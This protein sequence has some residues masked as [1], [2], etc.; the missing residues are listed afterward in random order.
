MGAHRG[1]DTHHNPDC[2]PEMHGE[3]DIDVEEYDQA[4]SQPKALFIGCQ[5]SRLADIDGSGASTDQG[6]TD[7]RRPRD[8]K[9]EGALQPYGVNGGSN[10]E[11][12]GE[13]AAQS[14][15]KCRLLEHQPPDDI[16]DQQSIVAIL[17]V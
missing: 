14:D 7:E 10:A 1:K 17:R 3:S 9:S 13:R 8:A 6:E 5:A 2:T 16:P 15:A 12:A 11:I 4:E